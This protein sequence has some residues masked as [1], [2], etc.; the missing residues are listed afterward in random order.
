VEE[1]RDEE[2][3]EDWGKGGFP[4]GGSGLERPPL[5]RSNCGVHCLCERVFVLFCSFSSFSG[6]KPSQ[7]ATSKVIHGGNGGNGE[8]VN[9]DEI[10]WKFE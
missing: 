2:E 4:F 8:G 6:G 1:W 10:F 3:E 9:Q 5:L 7:H